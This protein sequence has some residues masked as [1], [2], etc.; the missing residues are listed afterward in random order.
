MKDYRQ[1]LFGPP[2]LDSYIADNTQ[3]NLKEL[4]F[5]ETQ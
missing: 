5:L 4:E 3:A 2:E 1:I